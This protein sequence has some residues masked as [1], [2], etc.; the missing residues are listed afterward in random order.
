MTDAAPTPIPAPRPAG[1]LAA[2]PRLLRT[3]PALAVLVGAADATVAVPEA[4][5][6]VVA[7]ALAAFTERTPLL[8]VTATGLDAERLGD[9]LSC[10]IAADDDE[11]EVGVE[12][13]GRP[14]P[15]SSV[16]C[17]GRSRCCRP[18]RPSRSSGSAPR[19]RRW[20]V[21]WPCSTRSS[22][23]RIRTSRRPG[24]SWPRCAP[25]CSGWAR[26]RGRRRSSSGRGNRSMSRS[27]SPRWWPRATAV[28]T[29]WSTAASSPCAAASST[30][31]R[32]RRTCRSASTSGETRSIASP[33]SRSA[34]SARRT[35]CAR[36]RSTGAASWSSP[37]RCVPRR[38][39]SWRGGPGGRRCGSTS[40]RARN[41]TAWSR[42]S[43][44]STTRRGSCPTCCRP[45]R[46]WCWWSRAGSGT[47]ASSCST[48]RPRWPRRWRRPGGRR[49]GRRRASR[50]CTS[51][52]SACCATARPA[53]PRCRPCP[54][55]RR[56]PRSPCAD[57]IRWRGIPPAWPPVSRGWSARGT[58]S[59]CAP[60]P[61]RGRHGCREPWPPRASTRRCSRR[62]RGRRGP[63]WWRRH[64]PAGSSF[65]TPRSRSCR[66][67]TSPDD[68]SRTAGP[69]RG[70]GPPTASST[71]SRRGASW[72]TASTAWRASR[73]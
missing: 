61:C 45:V 66:R 47:A 16:H 58:R 21:A 60:P 4:A 63:A 2:V 51:R 10:L 62:R 15:R 49:R 48:R 13:S 35:T 57:S 64:S 26:S 9:D 37:R 41:S 30:C 14:V 36:L 5:Q 56:P 43:R 19:P 28:S 67:P 25:S 20:G 70:P 8:V 59:R 50:A 34:T 71:T 18:G 69:A 53:S 12:R 31:S 33:R 46:R 24:W 54:R 7:A 32:R 29:R 65:P 23:R 72:C 22:G 68:G 1:S 17:P 44:S 3:D 38:R 42:G 27:S 6:A 55:G 40:P 39:R 11:V 73:A 52:S